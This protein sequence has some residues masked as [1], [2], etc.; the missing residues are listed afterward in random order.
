MVVGGFSK[1]DV[2]EIGTEKQ[3]EDHVWNAVRIS[4][5]WYLLDATWGAGHTEGRNWVQK[6]DDFYFFTDPETFA[7]SHLPSEPVW[8]FTRKKMNKR[9]FYNAPVFKKAFFN[10][11]LQLVYPLS[12]IVKTHPGTTIRFVLENLD[13]GNA[14]FY[15]FKGDKQLKPAQAECEGTKCKFSIP[16]SEENKDTELV[17]FYNKQP[18]LKYRIDPEN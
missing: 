12:G 10:H 9:R 15:S 5:E 18:I 4:G 2:S 3:E 7:L 11:K 8:A 17:L 13:D 14:L 1:T 16:F 6:F